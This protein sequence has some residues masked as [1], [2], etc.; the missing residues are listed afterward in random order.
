MR[1]GREGGKM[2]NCRLNTYQEIT[3]YATYLMTKSSNG[4][5]L[6]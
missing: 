5:G 3:V 1:D 4:L 2:V 6:L